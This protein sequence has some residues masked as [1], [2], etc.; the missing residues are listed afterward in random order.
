MSQRKKTERIERLTKKF[1]IKILE[2][3]FSPVKIFLFF[4]KYKKSLKK[5]INNIK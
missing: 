2:L 3:K 1:I 4:L 5:I